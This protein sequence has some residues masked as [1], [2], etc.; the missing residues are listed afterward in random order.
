MKI[1][2]FSDSY[3]SLGLVYRDLE[4][5][6]GH[7]FR[8]V[9][10]N[11]WS[12]KDLV[13]VDNWCDVW[14]TN[15]C[16]VWSIPQWTSWKKILFV[17]HGFE[18]HKA[19]ILPPHYTYAMTSEVL[20][21]LF[22]A[23]A[24][25]FLTPNGVNPRHWKRRVRDGVLRKMGWCGAP[26]VRFKQVWWAQEIAKQTGVLFSISSSVPC[27]D[28]VENWRPMTHGEVADWYREIDLLLVT[29]I[30]NGQ[31]ETGPLPAFEAIMS[32]IPVIGTPVGNFMNVPGPK[33]TTPEEGADFVRRLRDSPETMKVLAQEQYEYVMAHNTYKVLAPAWQEALTYVLAKSKE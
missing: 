27:E 11:S 31:S 18:E 4:E 1:G 17:S 32:G 20:R 28:N 15:V 30:P 29:S 5:V 7:E 33:F 9:S 14:I 26:N 16:E 21:P 13:D 22:P 23:S 19:K 3:W 10:W 24:K 12:M 25:L 8:R 2:I 6:L